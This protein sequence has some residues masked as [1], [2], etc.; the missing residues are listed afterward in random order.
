MSTAIYVPGTGGGSLAPGQTADSL[1]SGLFGHVWA[2]D[3]WTRVF[4][5]YPACAGPVYGSFTMGQSIDIG[6]AALD[7]AIK[8]A[9]PPIVVSGISQGA[10]VIDQELRNLETD[11]DAPAP[12]DLT[13]I[14][15]GDPL[16]PGGVISRYWGPGAKVPYLAYTVVQPSNTQYDGTVIVQQYDGIANWPQIGGAW[17]D[18]VPNMNAFLGFLFLHC[19]LDQQLSAFGGHNGQAAYEVLPSAKDTLLDTT[20]HSNGGTVKTYL[21]S[22]WPIPIMYLFPFHLWDIGSLLIQPLVS[23]GYNLGSLNYNT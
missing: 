17:Y 2:G 5:S 23:H 16:R 3:D 11:P 18:N 4:I 22:S 19:Y 12:E 1:I 7:A 21:V 10:M 6:V 8:A 14:C 20:K 9:T 15:A 13:F